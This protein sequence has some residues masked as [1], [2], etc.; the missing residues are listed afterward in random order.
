[1]TAQGRIPSAWFGL[2][3]L[4]VLVGCSNSDSSGEFYTNWDKAGGC[5]VPQENS[6]IRRSA[7][8]QEIDT[9][10]FRGEY[11]WTTYAGSWCQA[12]GEQAPAITALSRRPP[13]NTLIVTSLTSG[14]DPF[15]AATQQDAKRWAKRYGQ[16]PDWV[17]TEGQSTRVLPQHA[18]IGPDGQTWYRYIG[19]LDEQQIRQ[20]LTEF[21]SG[22]RRP[23]GHYRYA[24]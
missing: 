2:T 13:E 15:T 10:G 11:V 22:T 20:L 24:H 5:T 14:S 4:L 9:C 23:A 1:M 17:A 6:I 12:S 19:Y 8:G 16:D 18:L 3:L 7:S 21:R